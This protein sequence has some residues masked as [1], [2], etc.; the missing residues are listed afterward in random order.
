MKTIKMPYFNTTMDLHI[1]EKNCK[2]VLE[3]R[4]QAKC[5]QSETAIVRDALQSPVGTDRLADLAIGKK[6]A[7]LITSDHTRSMP[8]KITLPILLTELRSKNPNIDITILI[9]TGLHRATTQEEL[10]N[11]FG[12]KLASSEKIVVHDAFKEE[13]MR[14]IC[15]LPS[16][17]GFSVNKLAPEC[18][19]LVLE[20][21]IEPHLFAGF[22]GGRKSI[23]PGISSAETIKENHSSI[24]IAHPLAKAG[25]LEG[26]P[27]ND[28]MMAASKALKP[29][30][31]LNVA[32]NEEKKII[33]AFAGNDY[34]AHQQGCTFVRKLSGAKRVLSD[35]VITT[36]GGLP[37][38]QNL[39]QTPKALTTA[40]E[41]AKDGGIIILGASCCDGAGGEFFETLMQSGTPQEI[42]DK[43]MAIPPK[44]TIPEQWC[45]QLYAKTLL[46]YKVILVTTYLDPALVERMNLTH[47]PDFDSALQMAL[48]I[49]GEHASVTVI[50]DGVAVIIG[51][52]E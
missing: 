12:E 26:N 1:E 11:M 46:L 4:T 29:D 51:D 39:Y 43:L 52:E 9:G 19:L 16:G 44:E 21:F 35:I 47:A 31:I 7:L 49:Q 24:A 37:L 38:D 17:A 5:I 18:D 3:P 28:D 40:V 41:C 25:I 33:A 23:L 14:F 48:N 27:I 42:Y 8:S 36:N 6:T 34:E 15:K 20:G 30:F 32:L 2:A 22:S 13:D 10:E 45:V 50:P